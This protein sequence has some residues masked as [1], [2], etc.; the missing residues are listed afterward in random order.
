MLG[1]VAIVVK[2]YA[3]FRKR[4]WSWLATLAN[5][6]NSANRGTRPEAIPQ[7]TAWVGFRRGRSR[8]AAVDGIRHKARRGANAKREAE[9]CL[10]AL[11]RVGFCSA[12]ET[13]R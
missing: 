12:A 10:T 2:K 11:F 7:V 13:E 6:K 4:A 3:L 8:G 5:R 9:R 1:I